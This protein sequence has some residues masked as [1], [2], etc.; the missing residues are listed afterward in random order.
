MKEGENVT[1]GY[2]T[3][4][5]MPG[6]IKALLTNPTYMMINFGGAADGMTISG[7]STFLPKFIQSQ[8]GFTAGFSAA[9]VGIVVIPAGG[10]FF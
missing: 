7:L 8:Y 2:G 3:L 5:D 9:I 4:K 1:P 10:M 6:V